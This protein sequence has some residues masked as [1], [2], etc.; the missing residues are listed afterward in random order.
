M[1]F[2]LC[3]AV[4]TA[5]I[6]CLVL[7]ICSSARSQENEHRARQIES[8]REA[9][10]ELPV[11]AWLSVDRVRQN[12]SPAQ[13]RTLGPFVSVQVNVDAAG[14]NIVGDAAN[15]PSIAMNPVDNDNMVVGWRQF[16]TISNNFR[17]A[18]MAFT[19]NGG[20]SWNNEGPLEPGVFRSDPVLDADRDGN[21]YYYSLSTNST[22]TDFFCDMFI[23]EDGGATWSA[24]I[25][26][27]G[28][29]KQWMVV[30]RTAST[31]DGFI[32]AIWNRFFTCCPPGYFT[33][34]TDG[35]LNY[36]EPIDIAQDIFWGTLTV[37]P[38]G[39]VYICGRNLA[40]D[41]IVIRSDNADELVTPTFP[42]ATIVDMNGSSTNSVGPNPGG[43]LGQYDIETDHSSGPNRGNVYFLGSTEPPGP[44]PL[45]I[46][47]SR[48]VDGGLTWS[49]PIRVNNDE[50]A[51]DAYN[52]FGT[53][54]VAPDGRIDVIWNQQDPA[55]LLSAMHYSTS[56]DAG[57]TWTVSVQ[58][59]DA[60]DPLI[61]HPN[62]NKIGDYYDMRSSND[63]VH[64]AYSATFNGEQ[65]VYYLRI[66][67][68]EVLLGDVN[69]DGLVNL[70]DVAPFIAVLSSGNYQGA[71]DCNKDG[72]VNLLDVD[73]FVA[74]L[75]GS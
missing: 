19:N 20:T 33:R 51:D 58:V 63:A 62:Q 11:D 55:T 41:P 45:D 43:L 54:S 48:S 28:G 40:N 73:P 17:Q 13:P 46:V 67:V 70:L 68:G 30:D 1:Y 22:F 38:D 39:E 52:W 60:F 50:P 2:T 14:N 36:L 32:H 10:N 31:S 57:L 9:H 59:T 29:D 21:I 16:D 74:I 56:F 27:G 8:I 49:S 61:G 5:S 71:A 72:T 47:F 6:V 34:S 42:Q 75:T 66:P 69:Q 64:V 15:E 37:G 4:S 12:R 26:A 3:K 18:G 24:P 53:M 35:G 25:P 23:S 44:D 65:D 7:F